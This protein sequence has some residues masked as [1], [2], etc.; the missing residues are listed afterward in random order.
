MSEITQTDAYGLIIKNFES[1]P[2]RAIKSGG[3]L[4]PN[5]GNLLTLME[6]GGY[7]IFE[8]TKNEKNKV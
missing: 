6:N 7:R 8:Q 4:W 5:N 1:R 2:C 3:W